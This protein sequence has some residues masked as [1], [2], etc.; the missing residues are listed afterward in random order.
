[1]VINDKINYLKMLISGS[2]Q[3]D[4]EYA[5]NIYAC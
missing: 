5:R 4:C 3:V 1:M 2:G